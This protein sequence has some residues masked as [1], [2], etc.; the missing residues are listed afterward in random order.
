MS[1]IKQLA[2]TNFILQ[3]LKK[4]TFRLVGD[5]TPKPQS[6]GVVEV[7]MTGKWRTICSD[8]W[9]MED[10]RVLCGSLGFKEATSVQ[11]NRKK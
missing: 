3:K 4:Y 8:G 11:P 5:P 2:F 10:A 9:D 7:M 1:T 6:E